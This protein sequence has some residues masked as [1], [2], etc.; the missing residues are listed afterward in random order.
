MPEHASEVLE[1]YHMTRDMADLD[2][3]LCIMNFATDINFHAPVHAYASAWPS[4]VYQYRFREPNSWDGPW[5]GFSSHVLDIAY[6]F[7]NYTEYMSALQ[8]Q[9]A[10]Q[11]AKD[12]ISFVNGIAPFPRSEPGSIFV[13]EYLSGGAQVSSRAKDRDHQTR[14]QTLFSRI[15]LESMFAVWAKFMSS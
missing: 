15:G 14:W 9:L 7:L 5:K 1:A 2:A 3:W 10:E 4:A 8:V 12:I 11:F 13:K 6:L